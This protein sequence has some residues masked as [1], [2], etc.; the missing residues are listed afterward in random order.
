MS[1]TWYP[2]LNYDKCVECKACF[3]KCK[4]GV[5]KMEGSKPVVVNEEGCVQGCHGCGNL[6]PEG[7]IKYIGEETN[8]GSNAPCTCNC[9]SDESGGCC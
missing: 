3:N 2:E 4:K 1:K 6:C 9:N 8:G 7:A 5:Y